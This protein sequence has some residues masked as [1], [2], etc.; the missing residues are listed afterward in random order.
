[1]RCIPVE[2]S[3][4]I[5]IKFLWG[6]K[7]ENQGAVLFGESHKSVAQAKIIFVSLRQNYFVRLFDSLLKNY[8]TSASKTLWDPFYFHNR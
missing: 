1:M 2:T 4:S 7:S 3:A 8:S 5:V 6:K